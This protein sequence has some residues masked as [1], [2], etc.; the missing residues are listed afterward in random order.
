M[1]S[2][3]NFGLCEEKITF[4]MVKPIFDIKK[5]ILN[6]NVKVFLLLF[7]NQSIQKNLLSTDVL[8]SEWFLFVLK[9]SLFGVF[10]SSKKQT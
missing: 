10:N 7:F 2:P 3:I 1:F 8:E 5:M 6:Y 4:G 9:I